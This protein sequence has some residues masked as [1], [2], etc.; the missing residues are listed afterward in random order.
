MVVNVYVSAVTTDNVSRHELLAWVND[1]LKASLS[2]IE[3]M[4][5]GAAYCQLTHL[6]FGE[7]I[8]LKKV[9][10][11][12]KNEV[13]HIN[14]WKILQTAWKAIGI[15]KPVRVESLMKAKFQDNYEFLQWFFKFFKA[16]YTGEDYDALAARGGEAFPA[17]GRGGPRVARPAPSRAPTTTTTTTRPAPART[18]AAAPVANGVAKRTSQ[19][20]SN[21]SAQKLEE[22]NGF[23]QQQLQEMGESCTAIERERDYYFDKLRRVEDLCTMI[24]AEQKQVDPQEILNIL[25]ENNGAVPENEEGAEEAAEQVHSI[26]L[27]DGETF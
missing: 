21:T 20:A 5:T 13:D 18:A 23:L 11:N 10:W 4:S 9:K 1:L 15:D 3:E 6:L 19:P 27:D 24:V 14:N 2:K 8:S 12:S 7:E 16:N 25:Y 26:S 17:G 22:E